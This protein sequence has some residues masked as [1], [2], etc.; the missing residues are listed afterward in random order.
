MCL[1]Y[2]KYV[3]FP[4]DVCSLVQFYKCK[5]DWEDQHFQLPEASVDWTPTRI[6]TLRSRMPECVTQKSAVE[7]SNK[8]SG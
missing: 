5:H 7:F 6:K 2:I 4:N 1:P 8:L 3:P